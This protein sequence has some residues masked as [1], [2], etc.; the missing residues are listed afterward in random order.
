MPRKEASRFKLSYGWI[1]AE[2]WWGDP[3]SQNFVLIDMLLH[4]YVLSMTQSVPPLNGVLIGDM[5][6]VA[7]NAG[8]AWTGKE[9]HLAVYNGTEWVFAQPTRGVRVRLDNP[10]G[11]YWFN[12]LEWIDESQNSGTSPVPSGS[13]YDVALSV[14]F[15]AAPGEVVGVFTMPE[16]MTLPAL[17]LIHI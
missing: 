13:K 17:S 16:A 11:W 10:A 1:R 7:G 12:G 15:E 6:I 5:Y 8:G 4:P 9:D 2:D 3:V 14:T